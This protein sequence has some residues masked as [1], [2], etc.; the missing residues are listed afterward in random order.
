MAHSRNLRVAGPAESQAMLLA[1]L[2]NRDGLPREIVAY[3]AGAALYAAGVAADIGEGIAR[4]REA[5]ASGAARARL[6]A[7]VA[8]TRRLAGSG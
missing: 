5:I 7:F 8:A 1:A 2:E 3:N 4:A 6:H